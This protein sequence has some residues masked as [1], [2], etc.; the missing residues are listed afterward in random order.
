M[1]LIECHISGFG[2]FKN[3]KLSFDDGLNVILQPDVY[4][5]QIQNLCR[6]FVCKRNRM[7]VA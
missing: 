2:S 7:C 5:R 4:K 3:Y 1:K 6:N